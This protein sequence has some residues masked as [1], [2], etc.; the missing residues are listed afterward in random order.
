[1]L[2][3]LKNESI[4]GVIQYDIIQRYNNLEKRKITIELFCCWHYE[5]RVVIYILNV[6]T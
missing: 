2:I 1:M 5:M 4:G 6:K 3:Y